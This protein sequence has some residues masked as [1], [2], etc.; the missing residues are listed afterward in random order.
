M[1]FV[2]VTVDGS[3]A[4]V[5]LD[6]PPVNAINEQVSTELLEAFGACSDPAV[7]A[8]VV[9]GQ[10]HFAAGADIKG[11]Q[12]TFD[13]GGSEENAST[14]QTAIARL[15]SLPKP[16][17]AAIHGFALGGGCE[18][19]LGCDFRYMAEDARIGQPEIILGLIPGAGGTQRLQRVVGFQR[20]KEI[21]LTGRHV[22]AEEAAAIGFADDVAPSDEVLDR[23][24]ADA[25][26][27]A[28]KAT[29]AIGI[30]KRVMSEGRGLS[31]DDAL[32]AERAAFQQAFA[33]DDAREGVAA[34]IEK[35]DPRFKGS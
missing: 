9:T 5:R 34:F 19:A 30:A 17:I 28:T 20:A 10:P 23:A 4:L 6:R 3:V 35:R 27:W 21:V 22:G 14:L 33:T 25:S 7:R 26:E 15:E 11:F 12:E 16:T 32:D 8:V 29:A 31:L 24:L 1:E 13:R 2:S 18:L